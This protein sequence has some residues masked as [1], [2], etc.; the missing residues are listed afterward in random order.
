MGTV[1]ERRLKDGSS[2]Y[3]AQVRIMRDGKKAST[4]A[5]FVRRAAALAWLKRK[6]AE[7]AE[8]GG[9][10]RLIKARSDGVTLSDAID[11]YTAESAKAMGRTKAQVLN[12]IKTYPIAALPCD[13]IKSDDIVSFARELNI[14][15]SPQ[16]VL[17]YLSHLSAIFAIAQPAW[18]V[19]LDHGQMKSAMIVAKRLGLTNKSAKRDRRPTLAE[20]E[21]LMAHFTDRHAGGRSLPMQMVCA[22][23]LY[24][25]RR[26]DEILR[27]KWSDL[28]QGRVLVRDMKHPGE[29]AGNDTWCEL[30]PEAEMIARSMAKLD[31]RIFPYSTDAVSASFTRACKFLGIA[32]LHFHDLRH[33]GVSRLFE[34]G[35][36][37]P[38]AAGISGHRSW[39]SLQRYTHLRDTGDKWEDWE[40]IVKICQHQ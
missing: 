35:K 6:E 4:S 3:T 1:T 15:R 40:W 24:S 20:M 29:K 22:F 39:Q 5:T 28:E 32:D 14:G 12:T 17:N 38:Q 19:P 16:T 26:Q 7:A 36:T 25:T 21:L 10:A 34:M 33:E 18:G 11:R 37:I 30:P 27:I 31:D 23:A 8:P 13:A 9:L 2:V